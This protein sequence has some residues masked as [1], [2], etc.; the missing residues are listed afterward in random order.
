[1]AIAFG[2]ND[3]LAI[4]VLAYRSGGNDEVVDISVLR[5]VEAKLYPLYRVTRSREILG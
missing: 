2:N 5:T 4:E 3:A 1:L